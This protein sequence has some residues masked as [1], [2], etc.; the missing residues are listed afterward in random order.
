MTPSPERL[1]KTAEAFSDVRPAGERE[2]FVA[3]RSV[4]PGAWW[5]VTF[6][7]GGLMTCPCPAG[8]RADDPQR[9]G[10]RHER[11]VVAYVNALS[12]RPAMPC[13]ASAFVD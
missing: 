10:C 4:A 13:N 6:P 1:A 9:F 7:L 5:L 12:A 8:L 11:R 3:S 2:W